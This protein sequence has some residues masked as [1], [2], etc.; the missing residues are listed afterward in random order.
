[1]PEFE[2]RLDHPKLREFHAYWQSK[3]RGD[4]LPARGD[5]DPVEIPK[6]LRSLVLMDVVRV[7]DGVRFRYRL[8]GSEIVDMHQ[9]NFT[10]R[11]MD[12][13]ISPKAGA[14]V[15]ANLRQIVESRE[16]HVWRNKMPVEGREHVV[17]TRLICPLAD[18][19]ETVDTLAAVF[20]FEN[21]YE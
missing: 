4:A 14:R 9:E 7:D 12:E 11:W 5:I 16:P 6:L 3:R 20:V 10:N 18:D 17:Y 19:G 21:L 8:I 1:M 13:T 15:I 2:D